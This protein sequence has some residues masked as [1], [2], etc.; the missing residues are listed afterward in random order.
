MSGAPLEALESASRRRAPPPGNPERRTAKG[1]SAV[2]QVQGLRCR[3]CGREYD[4]APIYTCEWCF[5]PLEVAY[6]YDGIRSVISR[7]KIAAGPAS[8]WRYADL[9]P[10]DRGDPVDLGAGF[11]P[12]ARAD[13]LAGELGLRDVWIKNDTLNPTNSFKDRVV[14]VALSKALEFGFK[15]AA[16]ASTGNLANSVA[17]HAT[18]AG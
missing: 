16:C 10:A 18:R 2:A 9:L 1:A 12:L 11:T 4:L 7:E 14:A 3:E 6:D 8:I 5:G 15:T 13:R 17:A